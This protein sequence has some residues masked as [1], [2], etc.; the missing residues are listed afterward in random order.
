MIKETVILYKKEFRKMKKKV[1]SVIDL[2][3]MKTRNVCEIACDCVKRANVVLNV[4][5]CKEIFTRKHTA[6]HRPTSALSLIVTT[7]THIH[8]YIY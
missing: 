6:T 7:M 5:L 1:L 8:T 3:M 2:K 4:G